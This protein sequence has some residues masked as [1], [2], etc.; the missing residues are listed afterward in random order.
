MN[1]ATYE[2]NGKVYP[3]T[4]THTVNLNGEA[5]NLP[6]VDIPQM[7]DYKWQL[8]YLISRLQHPEYYEK[9]ED[10]P[11]AISKLEE[12]LLKRNPNYKLDLKGVF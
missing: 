11:K 1:N 9:T 10:A 6:L 4:G 12:W 2:I 3:I 7:S 5:V 8:G